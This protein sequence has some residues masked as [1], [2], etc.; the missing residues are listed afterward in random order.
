MDICSSILPEFF[1]T[2]ALK[3]ATHIHNRVPS[4]FVPKTPFE[5]WTERSKWYRF[6][7]PNHTTWIVQIRD[8]EFFKNGEISG[9]GERSIDLNEKL[10]D[11]ANQELSIS[12]YMENTTIVPSDE[13]VDIPVVDAP[14]HDENLNSPIIQ[15]LLRRP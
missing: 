15:Q 3:T 10:I 5:L 12:L 14:P 2:E 1:W 13:V 11:A 7:C 9:S 6:Y 4:K 8:A